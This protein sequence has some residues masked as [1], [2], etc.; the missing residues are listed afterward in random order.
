MRDLGRQST[1]VEGPVC[2]GESDVKRHLKNCLLHLSEET[3]A[4]AVAARLD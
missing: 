1:A 4:S 2:D 3:P